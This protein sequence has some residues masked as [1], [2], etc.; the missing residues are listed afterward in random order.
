MTVL[1]Q[2]AGMELLIMTEQRN[3]CFQ[4]FLAKSKQSVTYRL[5]M[6]LY[7][8]LIDCNPLNYFALMFVNFSFSVCHNKRP[9]MI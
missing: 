4:Q 7:V 8:K 3:A 6:T 5:H 2:A 1:S 9:P